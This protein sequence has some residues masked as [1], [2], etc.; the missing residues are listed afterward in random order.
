MCVQAGRDAAK[1]KRQL[2]AQRINIHISPASST[3]LDF[4]ARQLPHKELLRA[5]V[6]YYNDH[7]DIDKLVAA[8]GIGQRL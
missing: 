5:S 1:V 7:T 2:T 6:H 8:L 3:R 4:D